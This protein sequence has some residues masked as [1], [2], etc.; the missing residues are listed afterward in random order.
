MEQWSTAKASRSSRRGQSLDVYVSSSCTYTSGS[1]ANTN[2][3]EL[4]FERG[5]IL[6]ARR[7]TEENDADK[8]EISHRALL[9]LDIT[10]EQVTSS[11]NH[12]AT[13]AFILSNSY[14]VFFPVLNEFLIRCVAALSSW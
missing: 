13:G 2:G 7:R 1:V 11:L 8:L 5:H 3:L 9:S 12:L 6:F 4:R 10:H 14:A